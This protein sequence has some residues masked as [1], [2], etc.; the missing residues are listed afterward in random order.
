[1]TE[2][3]DDIRTMEA[4]RVTVL[5]EPFAIHSEAAPEYTR[6]VAAHVD[7]TL[8][9]LRHGAGAME[10]F[11]TAVLGAMEITNDLFQTRSD[12]AALME[13]AVARIHRNVEAIDATLN[14]ETSHTEDEAR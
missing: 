13:E 12:R 5:G 14:E 7:S 3:G 2:K 9:A 8:R 1:V 10:P 11:P 6:R 4:V